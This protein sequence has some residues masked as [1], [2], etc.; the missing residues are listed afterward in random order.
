[1]L[2]RIGL[3]SGSEAGRILPLGG[4]RDPG[5]VFSYEMKDFA[6][7]QHPSLCARYVLQWRRADKG[8]AVIPLFGPRR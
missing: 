7:V 5:I 6:G 3:G 8:A 2:A 1:M 4:C